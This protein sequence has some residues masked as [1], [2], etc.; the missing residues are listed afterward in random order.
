MEE[1]RDPIVNELGL[2]R[3]P[4]GEFAQN[5]KLA[6]RD[7]ARDLDLTLKGQ[8]ELRDAKAIW[9]LDQRQLLARLDAEPDASLGR[10]SAR[11]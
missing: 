4:L 3:H 2:V 9:F 6:I 11:S 5:G 7:A 10:R 8:I 1:R